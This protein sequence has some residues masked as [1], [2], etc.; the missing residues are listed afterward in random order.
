[1]TAIT[2][3]VVLVDSFV[4]STVRW[5]NATLVAGAV[6]LTTLAAQ[7]AIP[8]PFT[9]VPLTGQTFAVL[10][11][12]TALGLRLGVMSQGAYISLGALGM[13]VYADWQGGWHAATGATGGYLIGF[14]LAAALVGYLAE[15]R[16]DRALITSIPAMLAGTVVI[17]ASGVTWLTVHLGVSFAKGIELGLTPFLVGDAIKLLAAGALVPVLWRLVG[18]DR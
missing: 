1:V 6:L 9:P 4:P 10:L 7:V 12:S 2:A 3:P 14:V 16:Q 15:R 5:R 18:N 17:Y 13:P 8:L 11:V